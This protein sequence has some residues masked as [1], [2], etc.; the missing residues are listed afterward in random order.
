MG[1]DQTEKG[2]QIGTNPGLARSLFF[3][4]FSLQWG[5]LHIP[6]NESRCIIESSG[7]ISLSAIL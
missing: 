7:G 6:W 5:S 1:N 2:M 3:F 4:G